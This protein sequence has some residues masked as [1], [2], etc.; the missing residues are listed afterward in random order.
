[1]KVLMVSKA[2]VVGTYQR[3]L[4]E[5][6][7]QPELEL[8]VAVPPFWREKGH[9]WRLERGFGAGYALK[10]VPMRFNGHY[11][12]HYYPG[13]DR[14][15]DQVKPDLLHFDEEAYNLSTWLALRA[16]RRRGVPL[17]F[18]TWQNIP[19]HYPPPFG[20]MED[21]VLRHAALCLA[22]NAD[23]AD[24]VRRK[25]FTGML[26][27]I[28]QFGTDPE[29]FRPGPAA[30]SGDRRPFTVGFVGRLIPAKGL[31][32]LLDALAGLA[33]DWRLVVV[34]SGPGRDDDIEYVRGL[35]VEDRVTFAGQ[36][37]STA[38]PEMYRAFDVLVGPS[39]TTPRWKEQFGR[40]FVE[41]MACGVP[42]IGS[43]S[44][45]IPRVIGDSG[46]IV[47]ENDVQ[48]LR[49]ALKRLYHDS[50]LR[51][52]LGIA[53]RQRVLECFTQAAIAERT[54]EAYRRVGFVPRGLRPR[55]DARD[56]TG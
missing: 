10:I 52:H 36:V 28:P 49:E 3:K 11:H 20:W 21:Q 4:E 27:V 47:P 2:L 8:T 29:F 46:L 1:M 37:A 13:L 19:R 53:G 48:A 45:E 40:M 9:D 33:A 41:A 14:L 42:V 55:P 39:L 56:G 26:E 43:D 18:F 24:I 50:A 51:A 25:G 5:I 34:G 32:V 15:L 54:V 12:Y 31:R 35:G 6:A 23:A 16:A 30:D 38:M 22:G 44:G 17:V 7:A